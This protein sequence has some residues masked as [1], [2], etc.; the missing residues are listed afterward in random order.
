MTPARAAAWLLLVGCSSSSL[1]PDRSADGAAAK[2]TSTPAD[3]GSPPDAGAPDTASADAMATPDVLGGASFAV[4]WGVQWF[5]SPMPVSCSQA[6]TS[7]VFLR[8][9]EQASN[10]TFLDRFPCE[11]GKGQTR[12]LI[13]GAYEF[14]VSIEDERGERIGYS[15]GWY[16]LGPFETND[17]GQ[18]GFELQSFTLGWSLRRAGQPTTCP[19]V[20][21]R[22]VELVA[23]R[24]G[25]PTITY[26]FPCA[27]GSAATR[28]IP[29]G[30]YLVE[31]RLLGA[32]GAELAKNPPV[33]V[34]AG[35]ERRATVPPVTFDVGP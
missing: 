25:L 21:A 16:D 9:T 22:T 28:A 33:P 29:Q 15:T 30:K 19:A 35:D 17:L 10:Q 3:T 4:T 11:A 8:S 12:Q 18:T 5:G 32:N 26:S 2:D 24:D 6:G 14:D 27:D 23:R 34:E 31:M 13:P 20:G 1:P 7:T